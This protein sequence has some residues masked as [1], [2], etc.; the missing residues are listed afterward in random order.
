MVRVRVVAWW[1]TISIVCVA[2]ASFI[3]FEVL[4]LDGSNLSRG[5]GGTTLT[6]DSS[7]LEAERLLSLAGDPS[8]A[9]TNERL[10]TLP[11]PSLDSVVARPATAPP[12]LRARLRIVHHRAG[13]DDA[14]RTFSP[15]PSD[16][17]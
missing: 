6:A 13:K 11:S 12:A 2:M 10:S 9:P 4:D 8:S 5:S 17:A 1:A 7:N 3:V 16:P 14:Q 15:T